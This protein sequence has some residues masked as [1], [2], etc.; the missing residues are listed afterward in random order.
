MRDNRVFKVIIHIKNPL[1][2]TIIALLY[3]YINRMKSFHFQFWSWY[4]IFL[5]LELN[6]TWQKLRG[7]KDNFTHIYTTSS[8]SDS[9]WAKGKEPRNNMKKNKTEDRLQKQ[10]IFS[11]QLRWADGKH[12]FF[13]QIY[14]KVFNFFNLAKK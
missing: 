13:Y 11:W 1:A 9:C 14:L 7:K 6:K 8:Y 4:F 12:F 2:Y 5:Y 10:S 3:S